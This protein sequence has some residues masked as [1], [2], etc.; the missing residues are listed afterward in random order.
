MPSTD[1]GC[2]EPR[3]TRQKMDY[4]DNVMVVS[5]EKLLPKSM[6]TASDECVVPQR[7]G[8][9]PVFHKNGETIISHPIIIVLLLKVISFYII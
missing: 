9:P 3:P 1:T 4:S 6:L 8:P 7:E 5:K 2:L